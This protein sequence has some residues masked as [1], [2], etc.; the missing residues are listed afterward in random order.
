MRIVRFKKY[1]LFCFQS[2]NTFS[3]SILLKMNDPPRMV[4]LVF[5]CAVQGNT[6][7]LESLRYNGRLRGNITDT[8]TGDIQEVEIH[9]ILKGQQLYGAAARTIFKYLEM[10][11]A[12]ENGAK[13]EHNIKQE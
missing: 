5:Q 9:A 8:E 7:V 1:L 6:N 11:E 13:K 4:N 12:Q 10:C 2:N 3:H